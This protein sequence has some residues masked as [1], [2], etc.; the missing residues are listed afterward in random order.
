MKTLKQWRMVG[1]F[2]LILLGGTMVVGCA[3]T[4]PVVEPVRDDSN[5]AVSISIKDVGNLELKTNG[6][7][8]CDPQQVVSHARN[9]SIAGRHGE[10]AKVFEDA[11]KRF[12]S[13][14]RKFE[15]NCRKEAVRELYHNGSYRE[16]EN[17][18][19]TID[20]EQDIYGRTSESACFRKLRVLVFEKARS[21]N[22]GE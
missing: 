19:K 14:G 7:Q 10:A 13:V 15:T 4:L 5:M 18:L 1:G 22:A 17:L 11:A 20:A 2:A 21:I 3:S 6:V 8:T 16:A 9:L 12:Q